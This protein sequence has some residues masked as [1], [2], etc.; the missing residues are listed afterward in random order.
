MVKL[1]GSK[2]YSVGREAARVCNALRFGN[3]S[4]FADRVV[5]DT[6]RHI[7]AA[8]RQG[9]WIESEP[10]KGRVMRYSVTHTKSEWLS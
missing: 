10:V 4:A 9:G 1:Y 8:T 7:W 3:L 5:G 2:D 6:I